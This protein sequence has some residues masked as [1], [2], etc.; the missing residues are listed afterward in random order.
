MTIYRGPGFLSVISFGSTPTSFPLS[1]QT[2]EG[3]KGGGGVKSYHGE[4]SL[5]LYKSFNTL[6]RKILRR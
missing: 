1:R 6:W 5:V 2:E 3:E 4:K